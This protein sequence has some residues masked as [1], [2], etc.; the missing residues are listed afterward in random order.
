[1]SFAQIFNITEAYTTSK[2]TPSD[3]QETRSNNTVNVHN[4]GLLSLQELNTFLVCRPLGLLLCTISIVASCVN[5]AVNSSLKNDAYVFYLTGIHV[6]DFVWFLIDWT[7]LIIYMLFPLSSR[8]FQI[9]SQYITNLGVVVFQR[10][11]IILNCLAS[12]EKF[13][14]LTFPFEVYKNVLNRYPRIVIACVFVFVFLIN[15]PLLLEFEV[16]E[17]NTDLWMVSATKLSQENPDLFVVLRNISRI[18]LFYFPLIYLFAINLG[19]VA[20]LKLH[21]STQQHIRA[22]R[23]KAKSEDQQV[24]KSRES[25]E[26][27][28]QE[29]TTAATCR[30]VLVLTLSFF[31][32]SL[33]ATV[34]STVDS[35]VDDYGIFSRNSNLSL[36]MMFLTEWIA[37]FI[38]PCLFT[39]SV[40]LSKQFRSKV[41]HNL[42]LRENFEKSS[43]TQ[44][45]SV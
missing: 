22:T 40:V 44:T 6:A 41:R 31:L 26:K 1:M 19:L 17:I 13:F 36:M 3:P 29:H 45:M 4:Q 16:K 20:A 30:L 35:F 27:S 12:S 15:I 32:L 42:R 43:D 14:K 10:T 39:A 21:A 37:Y 11:A 33:P 34:N 24:S 23:G 2:V 7:Y 25:N 9:Y 28:S 38:E 18:G 5:I 8:T